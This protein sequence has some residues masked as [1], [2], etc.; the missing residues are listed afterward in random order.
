MDV[1]GQPTLLSCTTAVINMQGFSPLYTT[2][3]GRLESVD[4]TATVTS[5]ATKSHARLRP[6]VQSALEGRKS[7]VKARDAHLSNPTPPTYYE[8]FNSGT[9]KY[10]PK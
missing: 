1:T 10:T 5:V 9:L 3:V 8:T 4:V 7:E 2:K 6:S